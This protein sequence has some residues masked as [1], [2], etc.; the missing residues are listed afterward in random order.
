MTF[1]R[2]KPVGDSALVVEF[3]DQIDPETNRRVHAL[4]A[5][6]RHDSPNGFREAVPTYCSLLI[7]YDPLLASYCDAAG[8]VEEKLPQIDESQKS[9]SESGSDSRVCRGLCLSR[10]IEIPTVY[11]SGDFSRSIEIPTM[12]GGE[13]GPDLEFVAQY[14]RRSIEDVIRVHSSMTYR[15]YM[16]GFTPGFPYL[17]LLD[18]AIDTPRLDSP[19]ALIRAG[20]VG[21]AGRQTG[22]YP[23]NSPGG[24]RIIGHTALAIFDLN[25]EPPFLLAP[26]DA[27]RFVPVR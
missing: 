15:V 7:H 27:V 8:W 6:F 14:H 17:G 3:G 22:I 26:G 21:I 5:L 23:I 13:S 25:R 11:R 2:I 24:W 16:M 19:R 1:P 9:S 18:P 4:T 10:S 12:Y 20:S